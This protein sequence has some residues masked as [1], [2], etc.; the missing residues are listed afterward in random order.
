M[1][2]HSAPP[3]MN[4]WMQFRALAS[5]MRLLER[6]VQRGSTSNL[7]LLLTSSALLVDGEEEIRVPGEGSALSSSMAPH[8]QELR[9]V[10]AIFSERVQQVAMPQHF[11]ELELLSPPLSSMLS[12]ALFTAFYNLVLLEWMRGRQSGHQSIALLSMW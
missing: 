7:H 2:A 8:L 3:G 9:F 12:E 6:A 11:A 1:S 10:L 4:A 5:D